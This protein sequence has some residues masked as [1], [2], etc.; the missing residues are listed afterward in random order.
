MSVA[1]S[2]DFIYIRANSLRVDVKRLKSALSNYG[3][4]IE[5]IPWYKYAY[6]VSNINSSSLGRL[7]EYQQGYFYVQSLSSMVPV[8]VL[9]PTEKDY[10]LDLAAAP[11]SK[12]TQI[13]MH[14]GNKGVLVANDPS[15]MRLKSLGSHIDRL[16]VLNVC[17]TNYDGRQFP[18]SVKFSKIL[19]DAPCSSIGSRKGCVAHS[20]NRIRSLAR[21]QKALLVKAFDLLAENGELVYSTCTTTVEE[22]ETVIQY[23]LSKRGSAR[24]V[25]VNELLSFEHSYGMCSDDSLNRLVARYQ[26]DEKF[27]VAKVRKCGD[28]D[29]L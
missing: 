13:A 14:M 22:N 29:V 2:T 17:I 15:Y 9:G 6:K 27:F 20:V 10:V 23:L 12:T 19:L 18:S 3:Y 8:L 24:L 4:D 7:L 16:G 11:G 26:L 1:A 21:L 28:G 5:S 25:D